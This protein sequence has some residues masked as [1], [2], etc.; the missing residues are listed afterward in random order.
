MSRD[1]PW[2][3]GLSAS[4]N[5]AACLL[6]GDEIFVAVQE[7]RLTRVKRQWIYGAAQSLAVNYCLGFAG[8]QPRDLSAIA[9]SVTGSARAPQHN[10]QLNP[11]V[12]SAGKRPR[13][14]VVPHHYAHAVS[15]FAT[16]GFADS[17]ILVVDGVGSP[18][19]DM[20]EVERKVFTKNVEHGSEVISLYS[21]AG[22]SLVPL[23][24]YPVEYGAWLT[25]RSTG[26]PQFGSL[27]GMYSAVAEQIFGNAME[28]GK[29]MGL[30]PFG[31]PEIPVDAF[32]AIN[33]GNLD[34]RNCLPERFAHNDRWP[35][36]QDEYQN[37]AA[38][39]QVAL[40]E[41]LLFLVRRLRKFQS[42][43]NLCYAGGVA[44]NSVANERIIRHSG[45]RQVHI[46][47]A[48]EDSGA[49][50]GAAYYAF[51]QLTGKNSQRQ[52]IHD[53][54]GQPYSTET[55][56]QAVEK[57]G[58]RGIRSVPTNDPISDA[59]DL[60]REGKVI[61]WFD[62]RSEIGPRAL[63]QRSILC[64]PRRASH[65]DVLNRK[66]KKRE[67]FRP[68][69]PSILCEEVANWFEIDGTNP[70]SPF[71][72]RVCS[73]KSGKKELVPAV[74]HVDGTGRLQ[75]LTKE[76]NGNFY[77]LVQR[78]YRKT[79]IPLLLNTSFN[80]A[81]SPIVETPADA[82]AC[83]LGTELDCCVFADQIVFKHVSW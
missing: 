75:T 30:A 20:F 67:A 53:A 74:V 79:G 15:A 21:A 13:T 70:N 58:E 37:L 1:L 40:E 23:E 2:I 33:K 31:F 47:P 36:R 11:L 8:I 57:T 65:K 35:L 83:L 54:C 48:A 25:Q 63:G 69:A 62:G 24:K 50:I 16:S 10:L 32:F 42:S 66:V 51:W 41:A 29:V 78:F 18:V 81:G 76:A 64:D 46:T 22:T 43:Q 9:L 61:G 14:F 49:A 56:S 12:T 44:L 71:M 26:M 7:E 6:R 34:F 77:E 55:I 17:A 45:F 72:L 60:L 80:I 28:A 3:L 59:A 39:V 4:H 19:E 52:I 5:G 82:I 73:F 27:G 38:S 68:F